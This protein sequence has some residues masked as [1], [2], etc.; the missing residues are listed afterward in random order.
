MAGRGAGSRPT[1]AQVATLAG[2]SIATVS[3]VLNERD[4][5]SAATRSRVLRL[6]EESR[7]EPTARRRPAA[8][9]H[10][11]ALLF[12]DFMNPYSAELI[13]GITDVDDADVLVGRIQDGGRAT[14]GDRWLRR[15][16]IAGYDGAILVTTDLLGRD[17]RALERARIPVVVIDPVH[18][19]NPGVT[20]I[21]ATNWA[22]GYAA[23]HHLI[24]LGHRRIAYLGG[25]PGAVVNLARLHGFRAAAEQAG[26]AVE[27]DLVV[28]GDFSF[29]AGLRIGADLLA[30]DPRPTA[31]F[32]ASD[33]A[34]LGVLQAADA[35]GLAVP[36]DLSV[37]GFDDTYMA[38]WATP[39]LTTVRAPLQ[40]IGRLAVR[41]LRRLV[42]GEALET[43][44]LELAT[45]LVVRRSTAPPR[46]GSS[47]PRVLR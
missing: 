44:H 3:K 29:E 14:D 43:H 7:Y 4:D 5:V 11:F 26:L 20:S 10:R 39:P 16:L 22:G 27:R 23:A 30:R 6:L 34:A 42:D 12:H 25:P 41:T 1:L 33:I 2:V 47:E 15:L 38:R 35:A 40:D 46:T 9:R 8:H 31:V 28:D 37:V 36:D 19:P 13:S 32:A 18:I 45:E 24:E 17:V 21:G